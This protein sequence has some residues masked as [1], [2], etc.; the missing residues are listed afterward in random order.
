MPHSTIWRPSHRFDPRGVALADRHYS[1]QKVGSPQFMPAG[2]CRVL[3]AENSKAVFGMSYPKAEY[4]KHAWAG[5][6]VIS[7]FRNEEAGPLASDMVRDAMAIMQTL[8][9]VPEIG[10]VTFVHPK[11][12]RGVME[13]GELV[14][15]FCF[16]KAGFRA[17]GETKKGLIAWQMLP[18]EMPAPIVLP[19]AVRREII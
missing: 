5:A 6:W 7:I 2:S 16:K 18:R 19:P 1:R 17:V 9:A 4:V 12:V 14:K 3:I 11:K 13:R 10:C 8:Y 15:G